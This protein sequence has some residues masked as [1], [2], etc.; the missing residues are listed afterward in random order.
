MKVR[1]TKAALGHLTGIYEYISLD[2]SLYAIRVVDKLTIKS[3]LLGDF[4]HSGS[5]VPEYQ[6]ED[7]RQV[8]EWPYRIVYRIT[9]NEVQVL[10]ILH[11]ARQ[12]SGDTPPDH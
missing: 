9:E 5:L 8:I 12:I 2:S 3:K 6:N 11:G 7:V 4:P 1:W 10:A